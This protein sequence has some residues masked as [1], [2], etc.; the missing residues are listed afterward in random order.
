M[1]KTIL[2]KY[3]EATTIPFSLFEI[4]GVDFKTDAVYVSGDVKLMK[5]EGAEANVS[6]GFTDE[7]QGNTQ[8]LNATEMEFARGELYIV[9]QGT[10]AWLDTGITIETYGHASA[11]HPFMGEGIWDRALTGATHNVPASAGK[12]LRAIGDVVSG[13]VD[14]AGAS[15]S[16]FIT[17]LT[18][19]HPDHYGSQTLFFTSGDLAGMSRIVTEYNESTKLITVE[20]AF[21]EAPANGDDFD[22]NPSHVHPVSE[23][24]D[25][26]WDEVLTSGT[27]NIAKSAGKRVRG[28]EEYQGYEGGRIYIDTTGGGSAG[29]ESYV[30]GTL[31]NPVDNLADANILFA[32]LNI[33]H[34]HVISGSTIAFV[35]AQENQ[36][37]SGENYNLALGGQSISRTTIEGAT[38][39]GTCSGAIAP[40]FRCCDMDSASIPASVILD[41]R[42]SGDLTLNTI[43]TYIFE[44]CYS[45]VAGTGSPSLDFGAALGNTNVSMR[46]YSGGIEVKNMGQTGTDNMS[47]EGD[48]QVIINANSIGGTIAIRGHQTI[49]GS[50]AFVTAGGTISDDARFALDQL[51][52][53]VIGADSDTLETLSDQIDSVATSGINVLSALSGTIQAKY[54]ASGGVVEVVRGDT[55]SIPYDLT[56]DMTSK[57]LYFAAKKKAG[58]S[59]FSIATKEITSSIISA[60]D[61]TGVIPI[62]TAE[63]GI[64]VNDYDAELEMRD[65]DGSS[66]PITVLKFTLRV[67]EQVIV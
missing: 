45:G 31:D 20:E 65:D 29:S 61:G 62:T 22:I 39:S 34:F 12:R 55:V 51:V 64:A 19:L 10:K 46:H 43:G 40:I 13:S 54:A 27:H 41:S 25:I 5:D 42:L 6:S 14:D 67:V 21:P 2:R 26:V 56:V 11:Q 16:S 35:A 59:N 60:S 3:G 50:A 33:P 1:S 23:I 8:P 48:G 52:T 32:A 28:I 36:V 37:F 15:A 18:G 63:L 17:D 30:N 38:I 57:K 47:I 4:D 44:H 24:A 58:D 9:D 66:S 7:G 49:T 53:H